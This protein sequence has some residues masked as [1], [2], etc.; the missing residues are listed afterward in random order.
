MHI[1]Y[2]PTVHALVTKPPDVIT[3]G[4]LGP[5]VNKFE[6]VTS[7]CHQMS[8]ASRVGLGNGGPMSQVYGNQGQKGGAVQ[9][10]L[11]HYR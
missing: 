7:D 9:W 10:G 2:L 1:A 3:T 5:Q 4:Q 8:I 6:Q 11:M